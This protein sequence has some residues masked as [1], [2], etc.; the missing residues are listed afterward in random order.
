M[1]GVEET[2]RPG[3]RGRARAEGLRRSRRPRRGRGAS[4]AAAGRARPLLRL[5][6][7]HPL[8]GAAGCG[9]HGA[10]EG[11]RARGGWSPGLAL[12]PAGAGVRRGLPA[13]RGGRLPRKPLSLAARRPC[14]RRGA[15]VVRASGR[16]GKLSGLG[17]P[18]S[19][20]VSGS[21]WW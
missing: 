19:G 8:P 10:E 12:G 13:L 16:L 11:A 20:S 14:A 1:L 15:M 5:P 2:K 6:A 4:Q 18:G 9:S 21:A 7:A 3:T 17:V